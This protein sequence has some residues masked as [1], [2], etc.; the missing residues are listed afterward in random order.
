MDKVRIIGGRAGRLLPHI[1]PQIDTARKAG[2]RV[3]LLVPEQYTLQAERE[4]IA[5]LNL[6]GLLDFRETR[7]CCRT[8]L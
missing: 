4:I 5:G 8:M 7:F 1:L 2:T 3:I 6:P